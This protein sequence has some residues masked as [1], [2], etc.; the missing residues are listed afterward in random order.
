MESL[1]RRASSCWGLEGANTS[2]SAARS[3]P[4]IIFPSSGG[5]YGLP[6]H[7]ASACMPREGLSEK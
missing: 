1:A 2:S 7:H 6:R 3:S 4:V 5:P